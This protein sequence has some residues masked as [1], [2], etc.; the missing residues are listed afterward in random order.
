MKRNIKYHFRQLQIIQ[1]KDN[2]KDEIGSDENSSDNDDRYIF[3]V[4]DNESSGE[5][6]L[7]EDRNNNRQGPLKE[8]SEIIQKHKKEKYGDGHKNRKYDSLENYEYSNTNENMIVDNG[9]TLEDIGSKDMV[10]TDS[11][12]DDEM[13]KVSVS[14]EIQRS[15]LQSPKEGDAKNGKGNSVMPNNI[16][17]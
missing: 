12:I 9:D 1:N 14:N 15:I 2:D 4:K 13:R 11:V 5:S 3:K 8:I 16:L 6:R 10:S 7:L 17:K